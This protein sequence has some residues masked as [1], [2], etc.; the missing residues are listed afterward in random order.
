MRSLPTHLRSE[1]VLS[2]LKSG[3]V[4][5]I[6]PKRVDL[7][8]R[9]V[10]ATVVLRDF[11]LTPNQVL[12]HGELL[13]QLVGAAAANSVRSVDRVRHRDRGT[14]LQKT[15]FLVNISRVAVLH[16]LR[17]SSCVVLAALAWTAI[18]ASPGCSSSSSTP[19]TEPTCA[20]NSECA[21]GLVCALGKCRPACATAADCANG[22]TCVDDGTHAVCQP[23]AE[24]NTPCNSPSDCPSPLACASDYRCRNLCTSAADCNVLGITGR[25][26]VTDAQGVDYCADP[27][28]TDG[29]ALAEAPPPGASGTVIEPKLDGAPSSSTDAM[30]GGATDAPTLDGTAEGEADASTIEGSADSTADVSAEAGRSDGAT[31]DASIVDAAAGGA[32]DGSTVD[33]AVGG[34]DGSDATTGADSTTTAD[35]A[36]DTSSVDGASPVLTGCGVAPA[37][38]RYFCEDFE[39]GLSNWVVSGYDWNTTVSTSRSPIHSVTNTPNGNYLAGANEVITMATSVDLTTATAPVLVLWYKMDISWADYADVAYPAVSSDG[40]TTWSNLASWTSNNNSSSWT[41]A[42]FALS[43]YVGKKIKI[44]FQFMSQNNV[45]AGVP[46]VNGWYIDDIDIH[47]AN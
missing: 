36:P 10:E 17:Y 1:V 30:A 4:G 11:P 39:S 44:R 2:G 26:C 45:D 18:I 24:E 3:Q 7:A 31:A 47:E 15:E 27:A 32:A 22:G 33:T 20:L 12:P 8:P 23:A 9:E 21:T 29:G 38:K 40:G 41:S 43:S 46:G 6:V 34:E 28:D 19:A 25:V 16:R 35:A 13:S 37:T 14:A 42:Q 5:P